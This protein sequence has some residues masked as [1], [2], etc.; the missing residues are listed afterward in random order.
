MHSPLSP[1]IC[2]KISDSI[3]RQRLLETAIALIEIPSPT[4]SAGEVADRLASI[5]RQDG[6]NVERPI[7]DWPQAPAV[8]VRLE[9]GKAGRTLQFDGHLDTVHLPFVPP[10]VEAGV[11]YGSG[12]SDM[13]GGVAAFVEALRSLRE[14]GCLPGGS[15]LLTAHDH[16]EGPWGDRRQVNALIRDGIMGDAVLMPEYLAESLPLAGRGMAI[17]EI[18]ISREGEPVHEVLRPENLPDVVAAGTEVVKRLIQ[19]HARI[20]TIEAPYVGHDSAFVGMIQAGEIYNQA[21]TTCIVKGTRRWVTPGSVE[22]VC[23][24]IDAI[25]TDVAAQTHTSIERV[26][27]VQGDAYTIDE[28]DPLVAAVQ[29]AHT[30]VTGAPLPPGAKPFVD[31]GHAYA[32]LG[33]IPAISHGPAATGAHTLNEA[34]P[35]DELVRVAQVYALT[36]IA[37]CGQAI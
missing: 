30:V 11:L 25:L 23:G 16:H 36:A 10:R 32:T 13:K 7:A 18:N 5:L 29:S 6:F 37:Y 28:D 2:R 19:Y 12:A 15:V 3:S 26:Y 1:E 31:D 8:V 34:V 22:R 27:T 35:V 17:F 33:G 14:S 4:L 9:S 24:E 20:E 21:P